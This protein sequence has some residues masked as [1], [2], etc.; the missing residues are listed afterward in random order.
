MELAALRG[1]EYH[2]AVFQ[3]SAGA[4]VWKEENDFQ[5]I[6]AAK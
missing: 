3:S 6:Y 1:V 2:N 4:S 5:S